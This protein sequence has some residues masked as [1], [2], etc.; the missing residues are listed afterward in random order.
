MYIY[1]Y[2]FIITIS[3][4]AYCFSAYFVRNIVNSVAF[5]SSGF[6]PRL[7]SMHLNKHLLKRSLL[8]TFHDALVKECIQCYITHLVAFQFQALY[9]QCYTALIV[10]YLIWFIQSRKQPLR[11]I[12][13]ITTKLSTSQWW[14]HSNLTYTY[15]ANSLRPYMHYMCTPVLDVVLLSGLSNAVLPI[16]CA[17]RD[18]MRRA[19]NLR[20][21]TTHTFRSDHHHPWTTW[22]YKVRAR[23][24]EGAPSN[25]DAARCF[26][27]FKL[28]NYLVYTWL[29]DGTYLR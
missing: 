4:T 11:Y 27:R 7:L 2:L 14:F 12:D 21:H 19:V 23:R 9:L 17:E 25:I 10:N 28:S 5:L 22:R 18:D 26:T 6:L 20:H 16:M 3:S 24:A 8:Y 13:Q 1:V 15:W 29:C